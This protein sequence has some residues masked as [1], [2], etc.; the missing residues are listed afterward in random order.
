MP[1]NSYALLTLDEAYDCLELGDD[2]DQRITLV[3]FINGISEL[4]E[5]LCGRT[6]LSRERTEVFDGDGANYYILRQGLNTTAVSAACYRNY[7]ESDY[8]ET[9][10]AIPEASIKYNGDTGEVYL[11]DNYAFERG[12]QNCFI[13]YTAGETAVPASI[14]LAAKMIL[15]D[16][17]TRDDLQTQALAAMSIQ[18]QSVTFRVEDIPT[19]ARG[20]LIKWIRP[21]IA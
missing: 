2:F 5:R 3:Q 9:A 18:G 15:K 7:G 21:R 8:D 4:I 17:W 1:L 10:D 13:T 11:L 20:I 12:F 19:E 6:F 14:K 16:F